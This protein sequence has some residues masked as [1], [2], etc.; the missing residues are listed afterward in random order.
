MESSWNNTSV[1]LG[2]DEQIFPEPL[3]AHRNSAKEGLGLLADFKKRVQQTEL[4][5]RHVIQ[6]EVPVNSFCLNVL[7]TMIEGTKMHYHG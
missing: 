2:N 3:R 4:H 6:V 5:S 7:D 1:F